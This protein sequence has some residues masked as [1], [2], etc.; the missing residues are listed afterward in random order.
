M[1][2]SDTSGVPFFP[3]AVRAPGARD[4]LTSAPGCDYYAPMR[5]QTLTLENSIAGYTLPTRLVWLARLDLEK[6]GYDHAFF[7]Y[8]PEAKRKPL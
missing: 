5:Y 8:G 4:D 1:H 3:T 6:A 2:Q 7:R